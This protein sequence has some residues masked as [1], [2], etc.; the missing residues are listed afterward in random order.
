MFNKILAVIDGYFNG[1]ENEVTIKG[2]LSLIN[3]ILGLVF[4]MVGD[5]EGFVD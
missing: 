1:A 2:I 3:D 4:G 5:A